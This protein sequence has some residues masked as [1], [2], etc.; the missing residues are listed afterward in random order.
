MFLLG[1]VILSIAV[2]TLN[3][4]VYGFIVLGGGLM[5]VAMVDA[6]LERIQRTH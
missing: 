3:G 5:V 1:L 2:G 4:A 6:I